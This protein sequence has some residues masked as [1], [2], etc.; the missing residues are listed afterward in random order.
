MNNFKDIVPFD[1]G[2]SKISF[3]FAEQISYVTGSYSQLKA[4]HQKKFQLSQLEPV[5]L[6]LINKSTAFY[7]GCMFWGGFIHERFKNEPKEISGNNTGKMSEEEL[8]ELDCG[9][10]AKL[11]IKYIESFDKDCKYFLKRPAKISD[12]IIDVLNSYIEFAQINE[13]FI[14]VCRT[15]D[16]KLPQKLEHFKDLS[17]EQL[18]FLHKKIN[19]AI[20]SNKIETLLDLGFYNPNAL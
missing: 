3:S 15:N 1:P 18:V 11:I 14:K 2:Y 5:I 8:K 6:N 7:L 13:N 9:A 20:D 19:N 10:E 12:F 16:V 17:N 4:P